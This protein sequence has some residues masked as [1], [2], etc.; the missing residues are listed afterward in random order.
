MKLRQGF[1]KTGSLLYLGSFGKKGRGLLREK[2]S[3]SIFSLNRLCGLC[4]FEQVEKKK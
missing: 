2:D 3:Y 1:G 4:D